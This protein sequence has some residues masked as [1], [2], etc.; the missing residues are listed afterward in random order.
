[1]TAVA[2]GIMATERPRVIPFGPTTHTRQ[3]VAAAIVM[4]GALPAA[5]V[6]H[7]SYARPPRVSVAIVALGVIATI[8]WLV[9]GRRYFGAGIAAL[10]VGGGITISRE[11]FVDEY[12]M[13]FGLLGGALLLVASVNPRAVTGCAGFLLYAATHAL[14]AQQSDWTLLP[15]PL[16]LALILL[17][18][19][20]AGLRS[21][22]APTVAWRFGSHRRRELE[23]ELE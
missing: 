10:A 18:W 8:G 15:R 20:G 22:L 7:S 16:V 4:A 1:M 19:G 3:L 9:D 2:S 23:L 21:T 6:A 14:S 12:A 11:M 5:L 17:V 13:V